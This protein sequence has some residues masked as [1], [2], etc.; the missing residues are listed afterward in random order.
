M[1]DAH[2]KPSL[3]FP[4]GRARCVRPGSSPP[5]KPF[6]R[7][8]PPHTPPQSARARFSYVDTWRVA[9]SVHVTNFPLGI[10]EVRVAWDLAERS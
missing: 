2:A 9:V 6:V 7:P 4:R 8:A 1:S 3:S 5:Y 10:T